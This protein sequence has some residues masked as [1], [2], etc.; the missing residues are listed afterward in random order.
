M[1]R[2]R[3]AA[4]AGLL[5]LTTVACASHATAPPAGPLTGAWAG[6]EAA[7]TVDADGAR[8]EL[9]C[10]DGRIDGPIEL[11]EA[12]RFAASGPWWPGPVPPND[13]LRA[14]YEGRVRDGRLQLT[15]VAEPDDRTYG[16]L[17]LLRDREPTFPRCQ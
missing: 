10:A 1:S 4:R 14:R 5:A 8:V 11:D 16:P 2:G 12:G 13:G 17:E 3:T 9:V 15:I 7:L 6:P